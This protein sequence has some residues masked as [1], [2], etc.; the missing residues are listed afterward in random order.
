MDPL[1]SIPAKKFRNSFLLTLSGVSWMCY[2]GE[3]G[4]SAEWVKTGPKLF[5]RE[6]HQSYHMQAGWVQARKKTQFGVWVERKKII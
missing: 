6:P 2:K 1:W 5:C 4:Y 3:G